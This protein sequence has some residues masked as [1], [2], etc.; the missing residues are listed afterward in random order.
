MAYYDFDI[1]TAFNLGGYALMDGQ[2]LR[3]AS[4]DAWTQQ[5]LA[6]PLTFGKYLKE[7]RH[8]LEVYGAKS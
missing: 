4:D 8:T 6:S 1:S 5:N 7:G 2:V 3:E